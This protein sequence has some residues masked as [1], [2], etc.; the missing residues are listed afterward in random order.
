M[1]MVPM[2]G[3]L[4]DARRGGYAL[5]AFEFWS[6]NSA[7]AVIESAKARNL[8]AI[9]QI[10]PEE[11]EFF[12]YK[13]VYLIAQIMEHNTL[14]PFALHLDH[15]NTIDQIKRAL[16]VGFTSVMIDAS[17]L[18]FAENV[19][20]TAQV[21]ET[22]R[23]YGA[24]VEAE[25]GHVGG[26]EST[27]RE[28]ESVLT[29]PAEAK[30]FAALT[31]VDCLAVSIGT[32]HGFYKAEPH[33]NIETLK[34]ISSEVTIPLVLHG[35]SGTPENDL[36]EAIRGGIAKI[37]ICTDLLVAESGQISRA[38]SDPSFHYTIMGLQKPSYEAEKRVVE[39]K[40]DLFAFRD[41]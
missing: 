38:V 29:D 20:R 40:M 35:G 15:A 10:C 13:N 16:D 36:K 22:A 12:G 26:N 2:K 28:S 5:G 33:L 21:V 3:M 8:P 41:I 7:R 17:A 18:P 11:T 34:K 19:A 4:E 30:E 37:N 31:G 1:P 39:Q 14:L 6:F 24:S 27:M 32:V 23:R 9:L 25:L